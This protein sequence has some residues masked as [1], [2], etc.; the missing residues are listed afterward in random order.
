MVYCGIFLHHVR[1][2]GIEIIQ[3][4]DLP[5]NVQAVCLYTNHPII[6]LSYEATD[7]TIDSAIAFIVE[8]MA[9]K[10]CETSDSWRPES[11]R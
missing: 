1:H 10:P 6:K 8:K 11:S 5:Q 7:K 4:S 3:V 9:D 2:L